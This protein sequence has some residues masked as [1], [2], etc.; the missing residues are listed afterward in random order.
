[1]TKDLKAANL[2]SVVSEAVPAPDEAGVRQAAWTR[3][4]DKAYSDIYNACD[5]DQQEFI[6]DYDFAKEA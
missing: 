5:P 1:M 4:N 3:K 2:W 6:I